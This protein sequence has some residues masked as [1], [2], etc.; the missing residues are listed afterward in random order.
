[1]L[2]LEDKVSL[3]LPP[4][5]F[6]IFNYASRT[7]LYRPRARKARADSRVAFDPRGWL[8]RAAVSRGFRAERKRA[9]S[10]P[11]RVFRQTRRRENG[12]YRR[13]AVLASYPHPTLPLSR[14]RSP[15]RIKWCIRAFILAAT[16]DFMGSRR[17]EG[18][19]RVIS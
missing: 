7:D 8:L 10:P 18:L 9:D 15:L 14:L 4:P 5:P 3:K 6:R 16:S 2:G 11:T 19:E 1:M 12:R 17:R 13:G